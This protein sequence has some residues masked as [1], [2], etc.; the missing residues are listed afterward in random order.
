MGTL[1]T[2]YLPFHACHP[3]IVVV[4]ALSFLGMF[5]AGI[6]FERLLLMQV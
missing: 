6:T 4:R 5:A 1:N 3:A 2:I